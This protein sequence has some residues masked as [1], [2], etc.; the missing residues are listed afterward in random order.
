MFLQKQSLIVLTASITLLSGCSSITQGNSNIVIPNA[1]VVVANVS[2]I[3][4]D[5]SNWQTY[6]NDEYGFSIKYPANYSFDESHDGVNFKDI[7][8]DSTVA[9][10][11]NI[12]FYVQS[13][14]EAPD[15]EGEAYALLSTKTELSTLKTDIVQ[16]SDTRVNDIPLNLYYGYDVP[17]ESF[18]RGANFFVNRDYIMVSMV[19]MPEDIKYPSHPFNN[20]TR[21][22]SN[23]IVQQLTEGKLIAEDDVARIN[24]F[25]SMISTLQTTSATTFSKPGDIKATADAL[26]SENSYMIS[27]AC[28]N[29]V[30]IERTKNFFSQQK[31][32]DES[33]FDKFFAD[34][35]YIDFTK[36]GELFQICLRSDDTIGF[37]LYGQYGTDNNMV[38]IYRDS[39]F[40]TQTHN[41]PN[42][43]DIG[44]CTIDGFI[45]DVLVYSCGG[46]DGGG[47]WNK[48]YTLDFISSESQLIKDCEFY[49]E[50]N[51]CTN[52]V[53]GI[54]E[55]PQARYFGEKAE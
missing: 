18:Y 23:N 8:P 37:T 21:E 16:N 44:L 27:Q 9:S 32:F 45:E 14:N 35:K 31:F 6:T 48:I 40:V 1:D 2:L 51:T 25:N 24:I 46:G 38:G 7:G 17:G 33:I 20:E 19:L 29:Y 3:T 15:N 36:T 49:L 39:K 22:W 28:I 13:Y 52:N 43:G 50:D 10:Q 12:K 41:V 26:A 42:S 55:H 5:I 34:E 30:D 53:L 47:G 54:T 4:D 11:E